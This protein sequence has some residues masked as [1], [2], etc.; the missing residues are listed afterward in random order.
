[1]TSS[2]SHSSMVLDWALAGAVVGGEAGL[3][4]VGEDGADLLLS[5][6]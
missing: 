3:G 4:L 1:M 5:L 2:S 6:A